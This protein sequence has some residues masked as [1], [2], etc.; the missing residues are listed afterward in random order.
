MIYCK[1]YQVRDLRGFPGWS[2][3]DVEGLSD[4]DI[5]YIWEDFVITKSCLDEERKP[6]FEVTPEWREFCTGTLR[7]EIPED[8]RK[9]EG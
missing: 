7:F 2:G 5:C 6:L 3:P 4:N 9:K 8:L 1:A